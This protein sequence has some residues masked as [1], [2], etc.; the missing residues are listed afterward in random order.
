MQAGSMDGVRIGI[1]CIDR[2][3]VVGG[4]S[5]P[6]GILKC[7]G[8]GSHKVT[9]GWEWGEVEGMNVLGYSQTF[10]QDCEALPYGA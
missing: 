3:G 1:S 9:T 6:M 7:H 4:V 10:A 8:E 2:T 5:V